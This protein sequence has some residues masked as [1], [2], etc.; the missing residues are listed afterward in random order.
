MG[1]FLVLISILL[2]PEIAVAKGSCFNQCQLVKI[3]RSNEY[4]LT[5][6]CEKN[7]SKGES[8]WLAGKR[9]SERGDFL[10]KKFIGLRISEYPEIVNNS[11]RSRVKKAGPELAKKKL[12]IANLPICDCVSTFQHFAKK[13][14]C[15]RTPAGET[16]CDYPTDTRS[17]L[18]NPIDPT[19]YAYQVCLIKKETFKKA[20]TCPAKP[21]EAKAPVCPAGTRLMNLAD[22]ESCCPVFSCEPFDQSVEEQ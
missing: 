16:L 19:L 13:K 14:V 10:R 20:D 3:A 8:D 9:S 11:C 6:A 15:W 2:T 4:S 12:E 1:A 21:C 7:I 17:H 5:C 22:P 18:E